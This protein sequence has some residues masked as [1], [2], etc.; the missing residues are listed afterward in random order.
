VRLSDPVARDTRARIGSQLYRLA[1]QIGDE[2]SQTLDV[3]AR[4]I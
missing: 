2:L 3:P 1:S 4:L